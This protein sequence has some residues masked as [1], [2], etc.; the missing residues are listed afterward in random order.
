M[1]STELLVDF[2]RGV[3]RQGPGG[4][5]ETKRALELAGLDRSRPLRIA[6]LGCGTGSSALVLASELDATLT[7]VDIFP[8][9]L[10]DLRARARDC[11][12]EDRITTVAG[13]MDSLPF[14][15][16]EFDVIWSEGA[17]Y[18]VGFAN[19]IRSWSRFLKPGGV[20][21][22]S[23]ITWLGSRRPQELQSYW[24]WEYPEIDTTSS[25]MRV[26]EQHGYTPCAYFVLPDRCWLDNYYHPLK[27]T[28]GSFLERHGDSDQAR[29][30]VEAQEREMGLYEKYGAYYGYAVYVARKAL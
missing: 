20:L 27:E 6:D 11:G 3:A 30:I 2:F 10:E 1:N 8:P 18:N 22:V 28:F 17:I 15:D 12:V 25:K 23:E 13:S 19:G 9:F 7:A 26:L 5:A 29:A 4:D 16:S 21:V 14:Q 24:E